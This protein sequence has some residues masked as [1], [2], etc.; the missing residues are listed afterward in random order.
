MNGLY[1][2][3]GFIAWGLAVFETPIYAGEG[4]ILIGSVGMSLDQRMRQA[5]AGGFSGVVLAAHKGH[6]IIAKGY[7]WADKEHGITFDSSTVFDIGSITKQFT[8]AAIVKLETM[9]K[10]R[11]NDLMSLYIQ[12]VPEDK[13]TITIHQLLTH[14][15]GFPD[16]LGDDY[17]KADT[18]GFLKLALGCKLRHTPGEKNSYSNVGYSLLGI[19]I[20]KVSGMSYETF[21][22]KE[23]LTPAGMDATGYVLPDWKTRRV[24]HGYQSGW[25]DWGT[26]LDHPWGCDG[27]WWHLKANGGILSNVHDMYRW[28]QALSSGGVL[29]AE[30]V[31]KLQTAYV[32][33][34]GLLPSTSYGYGWVVEKTKDGKTMIS[35]NGSNAIFYAEIRRWIEDDKVLI[36]ASNRAD[37]WALKIVKNLSEILLGETVGVASS[38]AKE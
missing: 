3:V 24:A 33:E 25:K 11:V 12:G 8:A 22:R 31:A 23:L 30:A 37:F 21:L 7:G 14:T 26:P 17:E 38:S 19:I 6:I 2:I 15:A 27:P 5:E 35:H 36:V 28:H 16:S 4:D 18:E 34:S 20:E 29:P 32:K 9:G 13:A 1:S 10:L